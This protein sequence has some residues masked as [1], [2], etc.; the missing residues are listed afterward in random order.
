MIF[1]HGTREIAAEIHS[2][3]VAGWTGRDAGAVAHHIEELREIGVAPPSA[4][5]L[6]YRVSRS[7]LTQEDEIEVLGPASSGE[8][9]PFLLRHEGAAWLGL[10]SD[11]TDRELE[12]LSVA[13]SKQACPKICARAI[14]PYGE[15]EG[16]L[17]ALLLRS[18]V[19][20][21]G[22]WVAYQ[23]GA[24]AVMLPLGQLMDA[25]PLTSGSAML[26]GTVPAIGGIRPAPAFRAELHDPVLG[27][28]IT[29][30]YRITALPVIS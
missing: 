28:S 30:E 17:D 1:T 20:E 23:D 10:A 9:E 7:L 14:W 13:A 21:G 16:H 2:L 22:D 6:F 8:A 24:L 27:R 11:H 15:V 29:L 26:C 5:P 4:T 3:I 18:W 12:T 25:A 19:R